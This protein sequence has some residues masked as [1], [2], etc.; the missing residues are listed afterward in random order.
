MTAPTTE[1]R[2]VCSWCGRL[3][4]TKPAEGQPPGETSGICPDCALSEFGVEDLELEPCEDCPSKRGLDDVCD[5]CGEVGLVPAE[6]PA[7]ILLLPAWAGKRRVELPNVFP[8]KRQAAKAFSV[9]GFV[10][11]VILLGVYLVAEVAMAKL[12]PWMP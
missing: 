9:C 5:T 11:A 1:L 6:E 8:S 2:R 10:W 7:P 3:L 12:L 4:G